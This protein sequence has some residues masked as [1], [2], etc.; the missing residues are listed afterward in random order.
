MSK[1]LVLTLILHRQLGQTRGFQGM[2]SLRMSVVQK[3]GERIRDETVVGGGGEEALLGVGREIRPY[4]Q[5]R[6][7]EQFGKLLFVHQ[8]SRE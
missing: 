2:R 8:L 5:G 6:V 7:S 4:L 1:K 3:F